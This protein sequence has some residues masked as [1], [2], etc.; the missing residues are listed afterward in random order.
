[1]KSSCTQPPQLLVIVGHCYSFLLLLLFSRHAQLRWE[2][3]PQA[4]ILG[5]LVP[6]LSPRW[7][8]WPRVA[9]K[10]QRRARSLGPMEAVLTLLF[11]VPS[12]STDTSVCLWARKDT[13]S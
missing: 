11:R 2:E 12:Q 4:V 7:H 13:E 9:G 3:W 8:W 1:M 5:W 6:C 10:A